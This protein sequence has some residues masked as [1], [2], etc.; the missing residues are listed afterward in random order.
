MK[1]LLT[2]ADGFIGSHLAPKL[3][4]I[5]DVYNLKSDLRDFEAVSIEIKKQIQI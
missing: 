2:G 3:R 5:G 4:D 1:I